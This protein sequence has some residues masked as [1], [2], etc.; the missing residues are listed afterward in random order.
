MGS[1][2]LPGVSHDPTQGSG[3]LLLSPILRPLTTPKMLIYNNQISY[4]SIWAQVRVAENF[5]DDQAPLPWD[6]VWLT[7]TV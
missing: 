6:G 4:G 1:S 5:G 7:A 2:M 3:A